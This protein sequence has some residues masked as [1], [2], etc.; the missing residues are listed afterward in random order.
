MSLRRLM[1][2][3]P[4]R[5]GLAIAAGARVEHAGSLR[6]GVAWSTVKV[7][8]AVAALRQRVGDRRDVVLA[9]RQS[10]N[11]AAERL[12]AALGSPAA[13]GRRVEA[14]LRRAG[15]GRTRVE[16]RRVRPGFAPFGQ[17]MWS[18]RAAARFS[19]HLRCRRAGRRVL[20][21][22]HRIRREHRW[23]LGRLAG[24]RFKGGWGPGRT[25]GA[26]DGW[27]E[28]QLGVVRVRGRELG[29]AIAS[30]APGH[31]RGIASLDAMARWLRDRSGVGGARRRAGAC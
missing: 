23:G 27:L 12:W 8:L 30:T 9:I 28:R 25:A 29:V 15:D 7:P 20:T 17:T 21:Q 10:D 22:M 19:A 3:L 24:A 26:A 18:L 5:Q 2:R 16:H 4:G 6:T 31:A 13:A 1:A 14:V 11:A